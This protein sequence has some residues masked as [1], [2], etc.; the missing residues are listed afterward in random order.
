MSARLHTALVAVRGWFPRGQTLPDA[1]WKLRHRAVLGLLLAH[2]VVFLAAGFIM[3]KPVGEVLTDAAIPALG[4]FAASRPGLPRIARSSIAAIATMLTS[5]VVVHLMGGSIEG[6]FHFFAMIP[7]VALYEDWVPFGLAV[8]IVLMHHGLMGTANPRAVYDHSDAW[9]HPW[10]WAVIHAA[11]F[12][13]A[14]V[15]AIV[16]WRLHETARDAEQTLSSR[17][18]HQA[19]HDALTGLPNR[20]QLME[21]G[22]ELIAHGRRRKS[23]VAVL[24]IDLDRFKEIND[25][26]GHAAGDV[27]LARVSELMTTAVRDGD[28]LARLGG[29]EFAAVLP[30]TDEEAAVR[31]A[32]RL[33]DAINQTVALDG[34]DLNV[35]ASIGICVSH[36]LEDDVHTLLRHADIAM[37]AAKRER[38]GFEVYQSDQDTA[39]RERLNLLGELRQAVRH[40]QIVLHYQPKLNLRTGTLVGVEALARWQHPAHG[41]LAPMEFIPAAEQTGIIL[42]LTLHILEMSLAQL[43]AWRDEG[44]LFS[45]AVN[46]SPRCLADPQLTARVGALLDKYTIPSG[47]LELEITENTLAH[48]PERALATLVEL[49]ALGVRISIDDFGTGYSSMS[50]LKR[51]PVS[52]LKVDRS[53]V[54]E[55]VTDM[56]DEM[57]VRSVIDLG[58]NL[59]LTVVA[60]GVE[61]EETLAALTKAGCDVAQ[62]Y[63][64]SRPLSVQAM[65][66][67]LRGR[68]LPV[69]APRRALNDDRATA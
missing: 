11:F 21:A 1:A 26:L 7:V 22:A 29:D 50:Y 45:V 2:A 25:V 44:H 16:N 56:D 41:L 69:P 30:N 67:W 36:N 55:M 60:E 40:D 51:L 31:V 4:A 68:T 34:V 47:C 9:Q 64:F 6:H 35:D 23:P 37:Y 27:L 49:D 48:D 13:A 63:H 8:L 3:G 14:C 28:I 57:L 43:R 12:A 66:V 19:H 17:L 15:G 24:L 10:K 20:T 52:E 53:F 59:G 18:R 33:L 61:N 54:A 65:A 46:L 39:T 5:T 58:H 62:G 38:T 42:P 32:S